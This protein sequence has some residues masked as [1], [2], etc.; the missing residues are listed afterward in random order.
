[1]FQ[2]IFDKNPISHCR[3]NDEYMGDCTSDYPVLKDWCPG[4]SLYDSACNLKKF[5]IS[6]LDLQTFI[7][8][9]CM[10]VGFGGVLLSLLN[11][12]K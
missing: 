7:F 1:M 3:I 9:F 4:H 11:R 10:F 2:H 8:F 6:H 5:R 12:R